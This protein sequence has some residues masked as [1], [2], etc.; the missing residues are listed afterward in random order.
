MKNEVEKI[1]EGEDI[2]KSLLNMY[3]ETL[4]KYKDFTEKY[5]NIDYNDIYDKIIS[6][7]ENDE[8][9]LNEDQWYLYKDIK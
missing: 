2:K 4:E 9:N 7:S 8:I 6:G 1:L 5:K 3:R